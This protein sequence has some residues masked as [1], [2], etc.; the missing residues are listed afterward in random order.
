M[1][2]RIK[3]DMPGPD[4]RVPFEQA[5]ERGWEAIF[6]PALGLPLR[7]VAEL[8]FGRGE[9]LMHLAR[10]A[11]DRAHVGVEISSKRVLRVARRLARTELGNVRLVDAAAEG[12]LRELFRPGS[13]EAVWINFSDPWPKKRHQR[14]RLVQPELVAAIADRLAPGG[15]LHVATD[16]AD[17]ADHIDAVLRGEPRLENAFHPAAWLPEVPGRKPTAYELEWRAEGRAL[18]FWDYR[19]CPGGQGRAQRTVPV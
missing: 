13:L 17:Y 12:A 2:R 15:T 10:E 11:P 8:G 19:K 18:C 16:D 5:R 7:L 14:R 4:W 9:F 6:A 1:S 3:T